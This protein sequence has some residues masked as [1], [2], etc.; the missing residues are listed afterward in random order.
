M[1]VFRRTRTFRK[2]TSRLRLFDLSSILQVG[3]LRVLC[4]AFSIE[5][6]ESQERR[7]ESIN[8]LALDARPWTL[9]FFQGIDVFQIKICGITSPDDARA[10]VEAGADAIGLNFYAL[11]PRFVETIVAREIAESVSLLNQA[12]V[13]GK[14]K[15]VGLFVNADADTICRT[16][17]ELKL[18]IVQL[19]GDEP[20]ELL[21][22][23]GGLCIVRALRWKEGDLDPIVDYFDQCEQEGVKLAGLLIDAHSAE[24]YGGTGKRLDWNQ[25]ATA[26]HR[27]GDVPLILA[28]GLT[29]ENVAEAIGIV[30]PDGIDTASG[31]E[32]SPGV[33][34]HAALQ[35]FVAAARKA[36]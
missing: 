33:K 30:R 16:V 36:L 31:V 17:E 20:V 32:I 1:V 24:A 19:H 21:V 26:R 4:T 12:S 3:L 34:D 28:G 14:V 8:N 22:E 11:S 13:R 6:R 9:D 29:P 18:D 25:L 7:V 10:A 15:T 5:P 23:L 27:L 35:A 2:S